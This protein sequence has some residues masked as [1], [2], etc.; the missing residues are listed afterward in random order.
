[1][2]NADV[3]GSAVLRGER[4]DGGVPEDVVLEVLGLPGREVLTAF[5]VARGVGTLPCDSAVP[6][7]FFFLVISELQMSSRICRTR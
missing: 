6:E 3:D 7:F 1:M 4:V 2:I 5:E